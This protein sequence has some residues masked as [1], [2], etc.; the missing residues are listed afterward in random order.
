MLMK[1]LVVLSFVVMSLAMTS[2]A[3]EANQNNSQQA[4]PAASTAA[5]AS[6]GAAA[7]APAP[8]TAPPVNNQVALPLPLP[9]APR[10]NTPG[11]CNRLD[12]D[13]AYAGLNSGM[14]SLL[15]G[16]GSY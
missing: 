15:G 13:G 2:F 3:E 16:S 10:N 9:A 4:A 6:H 12:Q 1:K 8:V 14:G 7:A 5:P 11:P